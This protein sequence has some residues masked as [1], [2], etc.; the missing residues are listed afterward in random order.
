M[1]SPINPN[2]KSDLIPASN[3]PSNPVAQPPARP[4]VPAPQLTPL[5]AEFRRL[6][7]VYDNSYN[8][9]PSS[10]NFSEQMAASRKAYNALAAFKKKHPEFENQ[11]PENKASKDD[12]CKMQ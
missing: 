11:F 4:A 3:P 12:D 2:S 5:E 10:A 6:Q 7:S 1:A 9:S 8:Y